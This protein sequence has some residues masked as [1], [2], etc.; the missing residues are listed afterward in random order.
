M[1]PQLLIHQ[2]MCE[3]GPMLGARQV[4]A[5]PS[6]DFWQIVFDPET[7]FDLEYDAGFERVVLSS[8][9][10]KLQ[11]DRRMQICELLLQVNFGWRETGGVR[12]ALDRRTQYVVMMFEMPLASLQLSQLGTVL[13]NLAGKHRIWRQMMID[14]AS[15]P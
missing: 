7:A 13:A 1:S 9:I 11:D 12:M 6:P 4:T 5:G 2:L 3:I 8:R 14:P 10:A 15:A